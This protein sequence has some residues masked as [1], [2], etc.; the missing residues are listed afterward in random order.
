MSNEYSDADYIGFRI[1][2]PKTAEL[3]PKKNSCH[4]ESSYKPV[5]MKNV[6]ISTH[7]MDL[8]FTPEKKGINN[9]KL[10]RRTRSINPK[11]KQDRCLAWSIEKRVK[12]NKLSVTNN[13]FYQKENP[14]ISRKEKERKG[15]VGINCFLHETIDRNKLPNQDSE[16]DETIVALDETR[17]TPKHTHIICTN[18]KTISKRSPASSCERESREKSMSRIAA[19]DVK[20][21]QPKPKKKLKEPRDFQGTKLPKYGNNLSLKILRDTINRKKK[22]QYLENKV[23]GILNKEKPPVLPSMKGSI[24]ISPGKSSIGKKTCYKLIVPEPDLLKHKELRRKSKEKNLSSILPRP[25]IKSNCKF[26]TSRTLYN[27]SISVR[28]SDKFGKNQ[29]IDFK[30]FMNMFRGAKNKS[31]MQRKLGLTQTRHK[32]PNSYAN[33]ILNKSKAH[34]KSIKIYGINPSEA[35]QVDKSI[36]GTIYKSTPRGAWQRR[37]DSSYGIDS[38]AD[39]L[40]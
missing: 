17:E 11:Q 37:K 19:Y 10:S 13:N 7:K 14:R 9:T 18:I 24:S 28:S 15:S 22:L 32:T 38:P 5:Y 12:Y 35:G 39:K 23:S 25:D 33:T 21:L 16:N 6:G 36:Q 3:G 1:E 34:H 26:I 31:Y 2:I 40:R 29:D 20:F 8:E 30:S 4:R 27:R